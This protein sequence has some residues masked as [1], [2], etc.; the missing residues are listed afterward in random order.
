MIEE[1]KKETGVKS[2]IAQDEFEK[3][4]WSAKAFQA[5]VECVY[6]GKMENYQGIS[7]LVFYLDFNQL[8]SAD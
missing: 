4:G 6:F 8:V 2:W 5:V 1:R 3:V 7:Q